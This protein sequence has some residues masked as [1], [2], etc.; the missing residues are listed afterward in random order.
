[1]NEVKKFFT[2][3][4]LD[5]PSPL[6]TDGKYLDNAEAYTNRLSGIAKT[7]VTGANKT[8]GLTMADLEAQKAQ[9]QGLNASSIGSN[10]AN[11]NQAM[12]IGGGQGVG[13]AAR[14]GD[15]QQREV[16]RSN[17]L[18][19]DMYNDLAKQYEAQN[20]A[21]QEGRQLESSMNMPQYQ[22]SILNQANV[23]TNNINKA[24]MAEWKAQS[25]ANASKKSMYSGMLTA[26]G[27][28][29]GGIIG[30]MY[31]GPAGAAAGAS[32]GGAT[33][34]ATGSVLV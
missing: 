2:G 3:G 31:G 12:Q 23:A 9:T 34:S 5:T 26:A 6:I 8:F 18:T 19:S 30:G 14:L 32:I 16:S 15:R 7:P 25:D 24:R 29:G 1:M 28:I 11:A 13:T 4:S 27:T 21:G 20:I 33:G 22:T 17:T 10:Y